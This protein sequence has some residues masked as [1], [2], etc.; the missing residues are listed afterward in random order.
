MPTGTVDLFTT[1][2]PG[3]QVLADSSTT[4]S[5]A[6]R[7]AI[8]PTPIGVGTHRNT[9]SGPPP[10]V[11]PR[12]ADHERQPAGG[13]ALGDQVGEAGLEDVHLAR[14]QPLD[15]VGVDVGARDPWPS[16]ARHAPVVRPT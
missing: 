9:T 2:Q 13:E 12:R 11:M 14:A 7:S 3:Q 8:P 15:L 5:T 1:T 10:S 4:A 6:D 16:E